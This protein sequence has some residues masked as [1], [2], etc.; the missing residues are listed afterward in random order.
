[1]SRFDDGLAWCGEDKRTKIEI[2]IWRSRD[3]MNKIMSRNE[4]VREV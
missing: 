3:L 4:A 2:L 1:L